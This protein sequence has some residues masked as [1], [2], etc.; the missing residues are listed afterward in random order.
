MKELMISLL[1]WIGTNSTLMVENVIL[2][3]VKFTSSEEMHRIFSMEDNCGDTTVKAL[4][5]IHNKEIYL[6]DDWDKSN[7]IDRSFLLH[8]LVHHL[9]KQKG[10][11]CRQKKEEEAYELQFKYL[12]ESAIDNPK[13]VLHINDLFYIIMTTCDIF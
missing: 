4:Y 5:D 2:P 7:L 10:Y 8:E 11:E 1:L 6:L 13:E 9:Q 3:Q 12:K